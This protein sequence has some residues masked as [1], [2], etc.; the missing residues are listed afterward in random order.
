MA[1]YKN[2][3]S[4]R[5]AADKAWAK[6]TSSLPAWINGKKK[7]PLNCGDDNDYI[8]THEESSLNSAWRGKKIK[9]GDVTY[10]A[11]PVLASSGE[12][13][14]DLRIGNGSG[15]SVFNYHVPFKKDTSADEARAAASAADKKAAEAKKIELAE[16]KKQAEA[17]AKAAAALKKETDKVTAKL[18]QEARTK[19]NKLA[20]A[21]QKKFPQDKFVASYVADRMK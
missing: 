11:K 17:A 4:A 16:K 3:L 10:E 7:G 12:A 14:F 2:K 1:T 13:K 5:A 8:F 19:W 15:P 6:A 20:P 21:Q 18:T 9:I